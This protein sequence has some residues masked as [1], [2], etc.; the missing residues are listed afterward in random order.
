MNQ[1]QLLMRPTWIA[2]ESWAGFLLRLANANEVAGIWPL[3][4]LLGLR[5]YQLLAE[6]PRAVLGAMGYDTADAPNA[7]YPAER[8]TR[9]PMGHARPR[10][11]LGMRGRG[12]ESAFCPYCLADDQV[13]HLRALW[14]RPLE[15]GCRRHGTAL[16]RRC[17]ECGCTMQADRAQLLE[18]PCGAQLAGQQAAKLDKDWEE[19]PPIFSLARRPAP[20][21][22]FQPTSF[23]ET[24]AASVVERLALYERH[25]EAASRKRR[26]SAKPSTADVLA[27]APWFQNWPKAFE[28]RYC[29]ALQRGRTVGEERY[30]S[31]IQAKT[32][33]AP[34]FPKIQRAVARVTRDN[35]IWPNTPK[36]YGV[37]E[38]LSSAEQ[39]IAGTEK[40]LGLTRAEVV[41]LFETGALPGAERLS[42][43][44]LV[45]PTESVLDLMAQLSGMEDWDAAAARRGLSPQ[46]MRQLLRL[47]LLP[48]ISL[49][50]YGAS[51][52]VPA[53]WDEFANFLL[54]QA[55]LLPKSAKQTVSLQTVIAKSQ[56]P[57]PNPDRTARLVNAIA[58][59]TL[60]VFAKRRRPKRLDELLVSMSELKR[61]VP[62]K[63]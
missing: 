20:A 6:Q 39:S 10:P 43:E 1:L 12:L 54:M 25:Q 16:L 40:L 4:H 42:K 31:Y 44:A 56:V 62:R 13:P 27:A 32:L 49:G 18:C 61:I 21:E 9:S 57:T 24:V 47:G 58:T 33:F 23:E 17:T 60:Q 63:E 36:T 28:R 15:I 55:S 8:A 53:T 5:P 38:Y 52:V 2:G 51:K 41:W 59:G 7:Q 29:D 19:L 11:R 3:G 35:R 48:A 50:D 37:S 46:A 45:V 26:A 34:M 22:T 14:E 30:T